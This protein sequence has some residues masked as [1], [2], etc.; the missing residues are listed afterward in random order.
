[1]KYTTCVG[2]YEIIRMIETL[3]QKEIMQLKRVQRQY[4]YCW[5]RYLESDSQATYNIIIIKD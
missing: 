1:M 2:D 5:R 4:K 3:P